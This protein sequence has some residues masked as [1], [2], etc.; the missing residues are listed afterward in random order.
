MR[1]TALF[2]VILAITALL[3]QTAFARHLAG[4]A[5]AAIL[6]EMTSK[7]VLY[8][9][10]AYAQMGM[11]STTKVM[12]A[13]VA[14]EQGNLD[15]IVAIAPGATGI[16]GSSIY[17]VPGERILLRDL[18]YG[19]M[20]HSG[21]DAATAIAYHIGGSVEGFA[22]LMN[23][24]AAEL[25]AKSTHF[26]N[27]HGLYD[28]NHYT[29]A[30]DLGL[31]TCYAMENKQFREFVSTTSYTIDRE[32]R[33]KQALTN[34]NKLLALYGGA[35]GVKPGYTPETGRTLTGAAEGNGMTLVTVT[36][37]CRDDWN[38]HTAMLDYGFA[39]YARRTIISHG[40][41]LGTMRVQ[42]GQDYEVP[43]V[44][45]DSVTWLIGNDEECHVEMQLDSQTLYAP[46]ADNMMV[47]EM[48]ILRNGTV[49]DIVGVKTSQAAEKYVPKTFGEKISSFF[50]GLF[51]R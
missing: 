4:D 11:A 31:I 12:T 40:E 50:T 35:V 44:S 5:S 24:K 27:P 33:G 48:N 36:L 43:I 2:F 15:D 21:N 18:L 23:Q 26:V 46:L 10:N 16:E 38:V 30:Y 13:L 45:D 25:G 19:L 34:Q 6:M 20:L 28:D 32:T 7:Q 47:A 22:G 49:V 51:H 42:N 17:L 37:D 14:I 9:Y 29:T 1:K 39:N 3:N 8:E 41:N